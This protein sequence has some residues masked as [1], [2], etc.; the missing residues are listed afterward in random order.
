MLKRILPIALAGLLLPGCSTDLEVNAPYKESTVIYGLLDKNADTNFIKINKAFLGEG[1]AFVYALIPDSNQY[2]PA[3]MQAEVQRLDENGSVVESHPLQ[4]I[5]KDR[6]PGIFYSPSHKLYYFTAPVDPTSRYRIVANVKGQRVEST[7]RIVG[8]LTPNQFLTQP[9]SKLPLASNGGGYADYS[10]RWTSG[11][12]GKRYEL[13]YR[14]KWD[15]VI[16]TDTTHHSFEEPIGF[17]VANG[18]G[19]GQSM[20]LPMSGEAFFQ[21]IANHIHDDPAVTLRIFRGVDLIWWVGGDELHTYLQLGS[22]IS[23]LVEE[24]PAYTNITNGYGLFTSRVSRE[25]V[26]KGLNDPATGELVNGQYTGTL[27]FCLVGS[28][29]PIGCP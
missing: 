11:S 24:R 10:V 14:F 17:V 5:E 12:Y 22:P 15:E 25:V 21:S 23:G 8:D 13:S 6:A 19:A 2:T 18:L 20:D 4:E 28:S 26:D 27:R 3:Q 16:G 29:A 7:T 1:D 9:T